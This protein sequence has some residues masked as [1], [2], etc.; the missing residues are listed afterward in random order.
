[1][2]QAG[3]SGAGAIQ[4]ATGSI[5]V[6]SF[7]GNTANLTGDGTNITVI[8]SGNTWQVGGSNMNNA[9]G[10]YTIPVGGAG[11]YLI[12]YALT[13][14]GLTAANLDAQFNIAT[15]T[16]IATKKLF[17]PGAT[18][19]SGGYSQ[20]ND[21]TIIDGVEGQTIYVEGQVSGGAKVVGYYGEFFGLYS[22]IEIFKLSD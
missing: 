8:W 7:T 17:N 19:D 5:G 18:R 15:S 14:S 9:T 21:S 10:V 1:M 12:S 11:R 16:S 2:S 22:H 4:P 6:Q 13:L 20:F 3:L